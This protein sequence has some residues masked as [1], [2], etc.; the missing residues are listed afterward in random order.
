M[1]RLGDSL[2]PQPELG[3]QLHRCARRR[4][5]GHG[6]HEGINSTD[7]S[8]IPAQVTP[9][10]PHTRNVSE[11]VG[12]QDNEDLCS[13]EAYTLWYGEIA[14]SCKVFRIFNQ[15]YRPK[16]M[17]NRPIVSTACNFN[18]THNNNKFKNFKK[19]HGAGQTKTRVWAEFGPQV[20]FFKPDLEFFISS[21]QSHLPRVALLR[22]HDPHHRLSQGD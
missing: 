10:V 6:H 21:E 7:T 11:Q 17:G 18:K 5:H 4:P 20:T 9:A 13:R 16:I 19:T 1:P 22:V 2:G 15:I 8:S 3:S 12:E 14:P